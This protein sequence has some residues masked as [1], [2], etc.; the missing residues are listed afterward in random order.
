MSHLSNLSVL[1]FARP[2]PPR[3]HR[4]DNNGGSNWSTV[5]ELSPGGQG[6]V[7]GPELDPAAP[8]PPAPRPFTH[9]NPPLND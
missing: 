5:V 8:S 4:W 2:A 6:P 3:L 1:S 7:T 9:S